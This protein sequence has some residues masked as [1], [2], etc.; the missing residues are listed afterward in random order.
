MAAVRACLSSFKFITNLS[1]FGTKRKF[2]VTYWLDVVLLQEEARHARR[3]TQPASQWVVSRGLFQTRVKWPGVKLTAHLHLAWKVTNEW[4]FISTSPY[5]F[6]VWRKDRDYITFSLKVTFSI[7]YQITLKEMEVS[8]AGTL[9]VLG[10][11][12]LG[13]NYKHPDLLSRK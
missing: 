11:K 4:S 6:M 8:P 10:S 2:V 9:G 13:A 5:V 1:P 3:E 7:S 12:T